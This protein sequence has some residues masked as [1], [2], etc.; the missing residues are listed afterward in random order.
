M[1]KVVK[2]ANSGKGLYLKKI[3]NCAYDVISS[4]KIS[5]DEWRVYSKSR[6]VPLKR[7]EDSS[8]ETY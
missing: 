6:D 2:T 1:I 7:I 3:Y 8:I 4:K 5:R